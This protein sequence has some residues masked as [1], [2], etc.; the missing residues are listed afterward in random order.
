ME[1]LSLLCKE[2]T[3]SSF[4]NKSRDLQKKKLEQEIK[5]HDRKLMTNLKIVVKKFNIPNQSSTQELFE[6]SIINPRDEG[7]EWHRRQNLY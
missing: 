6:L 3:W 5:V 2:R 4:L 7:K 1:V